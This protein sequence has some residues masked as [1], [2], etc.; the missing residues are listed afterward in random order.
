MD[1]YLTTQNALESWERDTGC[2]FT[3]S[4]NEDYYVASNNWNTDVIVIS[5]DEA[6]PVARY[7]LSATES[8]CEWT[9]SDTAETKQLTYRELGTAEDDVDLTTF[10][11]V[12]DITN[13]IIGKISDGKTARRLLSS[14][15][16]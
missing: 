16:L 7:Y 1:N 9:T 4:D 15:E 3:D 2:T 13:E 6:S 8:I 14:E 12:E 5:K 11:S 10:S